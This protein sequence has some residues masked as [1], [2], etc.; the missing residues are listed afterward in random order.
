M[1][2]SIAQM[3][4]P[5]VAVILPCYNEEAAIAGVVAAFRKA[6][7]V[8][9]I[10]VFDNASTD[11]TAAAAKAAG[12][13]VR[14]EPMKGK[15]NAVRRAFA[16]I[17]A[18]IYVMADGDG[19]YDAASAPRLVDC[20]RRETLDMVV[21]I[22][23]TSAD[24]AYRPG[25]VLGNRVFSWLFRNLFRSEFTDILSGF[26]VFSRRFV[27][28]FPSTS[29]GFEIELEMSTHAALLRLPTKEIVTPYG[30]RTKGGE[31][32]LNTYS[33]GF[34]ILRR[35]MSFLRLHRPRF[36]Y[37]IVAFAGGLLSIG[38]AF[39]IVME[40]IETGLV[41]RFPTAI[42]ATSIMLAA[43]LIFVMGVILDSQ[44]RYF[45]ETKRLAYLRIGPPPRLDKS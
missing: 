33:D 1:V 14:V 30:E 22:R 3:P 9:D 5:T 19:T 16:D 12:A 43:F 11:G 25:H 6:L 26:R 23:E 36:V 34:R 15:G 10:F 41:P 37:S 8:S 27:K 2:D 17:D 20:L 28:S 45:S 18:D 44:A 7:P 24:A 42:L 40:F 4:S 38:L 13:I 21:G 31:S 32:K 39:P 29:K 35:M